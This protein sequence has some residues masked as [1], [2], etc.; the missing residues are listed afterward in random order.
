MILALRENNQWTIDAPKSAYATI[1]L[2][3][4]KFGEYLAKN[5]SSLEAEVRIP[6]AARWGATVFVGVACLYAGPLN[7]TESENVYPNIG[8]GVQYVIKQKDGPKSRIR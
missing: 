7:Y 1:T 3:G 8:A 5:M 2:R 6:L 4:Y